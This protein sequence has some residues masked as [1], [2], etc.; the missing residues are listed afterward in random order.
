MFPVSAEEALRAALA[1]RE[2]EAQ[3]LSVE[4]AAGR[5]HGNGR[6]TVWRWRVE[7]GKE[8]SFEHLR[9]WFLTGLNDG[10]VETAAPEPAIQAR[11]PER[12][13]KAPAERRAA[14]RRLSP[15]RGSARLTGRSLLRA[16]RWLLEWGAEPS[17]IEESRV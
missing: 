5:V 11:P 17:A 4:K 14:G 16:G 6:P 12:T 9:G 3:R 1:S 8:E 2:S 13:Q 15:L 7:P 10:A